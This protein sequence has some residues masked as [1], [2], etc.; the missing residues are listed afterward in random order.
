M[1]IISNNTGLSMCIVIN[2][3]NEVEIVI[4]PAT[5]LKKCQG[6]PKNIEIVC[7]SINIPVDA[8]TNPSEINGNLIANSMNFTALDIISV[9]INIKIP[10]SMI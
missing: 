8:N 4:I 9:L 10:L 1:L 5:I 6:P 2:N 7:T 3:I